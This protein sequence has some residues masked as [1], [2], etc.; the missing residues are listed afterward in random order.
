MSYLD[1]YSSNYKNDSFINFV[2]ICL[3]LDKFTLL[4]YF[5]PKACY[6]LSHFFL[7]DSNPYP[8]V[9]LAFSK[10]PT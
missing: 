5:H 1:K 6:F 8:F 3:H 7:S 2:K 10:D 4:F 9:P